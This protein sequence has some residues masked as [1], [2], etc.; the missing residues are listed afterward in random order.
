[1]QIALNYCRNLQKETVNYLRL[2]DVSSFPVRV[3][4]CAAPSAFSPDDSDV[5]VFFFLH[6]QIGPIALPR[7][8]SIHYALMSLGICWLPW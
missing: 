1:M 6:N 5:C 8:N 4:I 2:N 3:C 7:T